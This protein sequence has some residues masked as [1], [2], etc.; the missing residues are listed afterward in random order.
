MS[1]LCTAERMLR[2]KLEEWEKEMFLFPRACRRCWAT[3]KSGMLDCPDCMCVSYC[4]EECQEKDATVHSAETVCKEL[5][6]AMACDNFECSVNIAVPPLP[7]DL[8]NSFMGTPANMDAFLEQTADRSSSSNGDKIDSGLAIMEKKFLTDRLSGPMTLLQAVSLKLAR[9]ISVETAAHLVIHVVGANVM[10]MLG[11]IKWEVL[12][13]RLPQCL[14]LRLVFIGPELEAHEGQDGECPW[15][16]PCA[17]CRKKNKSVVYEIRRGTY[18]KYASSEAYIVPDL[19]AAFN[20][21][22][23]EFELQPDK[24]TW[25]PSLPLLVR[26]PGVPLVFTSYTLTEALKDLKLIKEACEEL[27]VDVAAERNPFRSQRPI[28]DFEFDGGNDVF[29]SNNYYS[30]VRRQ[31]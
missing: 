18:E 10:E 1:A 5:R 6:Y 24:E 16:E 2:R 25:R 17:E 7:S 23:H 9:G 14:N 13:H 27:L 4:S 28:R 30:V 31:G 26:H 3:K 29:Y 21:G 22:F 8:D 20:C 15:L 19:V 11:M 12:G